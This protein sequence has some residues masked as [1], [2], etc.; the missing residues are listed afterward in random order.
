MPMTSKQLRN[1]DNA[2]FITRQTR[3]QLLKQRDTQKN[4]DR[5]FEGQPGATKKERESCN[6]LSD[7]RRYRKGHEPPLPSATSAKRTSLMAYATV[8]PRDSKPPPGGGEP[9]H[10][11]NIKVPICLQTARRTATTSLPP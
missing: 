7:P 9:K 1:G 8:A 5:I 2:I 4:T 11:H 3:N 10:P 6:K